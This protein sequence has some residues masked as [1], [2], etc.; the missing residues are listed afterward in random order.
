V[1]DFHFCFFLPYVKIFFGLLSARSH[2]FG[3]RG[4]LPVPHPC[5][6]IVPQKNGKIN[7]QN[8]QK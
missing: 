3:G 5:A 8:A 1:I 7:R 4:V 6:S 2:L